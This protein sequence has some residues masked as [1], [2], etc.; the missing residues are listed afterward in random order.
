MAPRP[1]FR[2]AD[3]SDH[4]QI[5]ALLEAELPGSPGVSGLLAEPS[6]LAVIAEL[7]G[8]LAGA[9]LVAP[10]RERWAPGS[11]IP[12]GPAPLAE[13][14]ALAVAPSYRRSGIGTQLALA[15]RD[16]AQHAGANRIEAN[17]AESN[18][19]IHN[20]LG[21]LGWRPTALEHETY[22]DGQ[23]AFRIAAQIGG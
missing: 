17:V 15:A 11:P 16:F 10:C 8:E 12:E 19:A 23:R 14:L 18:V 20:L 13:L 6:V 3:R 9:M 5:A 1:T 4:P 21:G 7:E 22:A 2:P